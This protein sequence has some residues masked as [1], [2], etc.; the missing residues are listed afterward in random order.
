MNR[1]RIRVRFEG[2]P[3]VA[4]AFCIGVIPNG[5]GRARK[6]TLAFEA[7]SNPIKLTNNGA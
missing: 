3:S 6:G 2:F 5:V 4:A 7:D 1:I